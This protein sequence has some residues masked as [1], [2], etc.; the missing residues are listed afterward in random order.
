MRKM[1]VALLALMLM[2]GSTASAAMAQGA[3][4]PE[5]PVA[6]EATEPGETAFARGLNAPATYFTERG[7]AIATLTI[8]DIERGWQEFRENDAPKPG[9]EY[10][11]VTF[12]ISS[13]ASSGVNIE[14]RDFLMVDGLGLT[15][16]NSRVRTDDE[17]ATELLDGKTTVASGESSEFTLVF[18]VYQSSELGVLIWQPGSNVAIMVDLTGI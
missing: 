3:A 10:L 11:A 4:T 12:E 7:D 17:S 8:V 14:P 1:W 5:A 6:D 13:L 9:I 15:E 16:S 2:V 18:E